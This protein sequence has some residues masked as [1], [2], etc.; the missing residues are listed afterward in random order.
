MLFSLRCYLESFLIALNDGSAYVLFQTSCMRLA[1]VNVFLV[2]VSLQMSYLGW[3]TSVG[4]CFSNCGASSMRYARHFHVPL[5]EGWN[6]PQFPS[7]RLSKSHPASP[8]PVCARDSLAPYW[9]SPWL[10]EAP[11]RSSVMGICQKKS[12]IWRDSNPRLLWPLLHKQ[13]LP[14]LVCVAHCPKG[15]PGHQAS[16]KYSVVSAEAGALTIRPHTLRNFS[17]YAEQ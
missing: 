10:Q 14:Q 17:K 11:A 3:T 4:I 12:W 15:Q 13:V 6:I 9:S 7:E 1:I 2:L 5:L 8:T 16:T